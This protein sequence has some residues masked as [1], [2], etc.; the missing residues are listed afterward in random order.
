MR[1]PGRRE[2][3]A[4]HAAEHDGRQGEL[5][6]IAGKAG[7]R[8]TTAGPSLHCAE[9]GEDRGGPVAIDIVEPD[10]ERG[11]G[12]LKAC[13]HGLLKTCY[14]SW[15]GGGCTPP[16][17]LPLRIVEQPSGDADPVRPL[18]PRAQWM[19]APKEE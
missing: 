9:R 10:G 17:G 7:L 13:L 11:R 19:R 4:F 3:P 5:T 15:G 18:P 12:E 16:S 14:L 6:C 2:A 1:P 8:R